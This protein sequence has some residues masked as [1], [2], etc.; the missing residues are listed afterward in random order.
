LLW[1]WLL[2]LQLEVE[3]KARPPRRELLLL[4]KGGISGN[5]GA[6]NAKTETRGLYFR[7]KSKKLHQPQLGFVLVLA[8]SPL[9]RQVKVYD[10]LN[11]RVAIRGTS[12]AA[13]HVAERWRV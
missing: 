4:A 10:E 7:R 3:L 12:A 13:C 11:H 6:K 9:R 5:A 2:L 1:F 8:E